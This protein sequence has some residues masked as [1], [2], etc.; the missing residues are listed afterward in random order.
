MQ[1]IAPMNVVFFGV[2]IW[3][4]K[5][6][7]FRGNS[8]YRPLLFF[9]FVYVAISLYH[10]SMRGFFPQTLAANYYFVLA[11]SNIIFILI[12]IT[13]YVLSIAKGIDNRSKEGLLGVYERW[14]A[15]LTKRKSR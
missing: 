9:Y 6:K 3:L 5:A 14:L 4:F 13:L 2:F 7:A 8:F 11:A 15:R 1:F 12:I 10:L